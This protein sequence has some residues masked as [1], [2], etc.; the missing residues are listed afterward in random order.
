M[1]K[2]ITFKTNLS[3]QKSEQESLKEI[4]I[5]VNTFH[6]KE[7][8]IFTKLYKFYNGITRVLIKKGR[9]RV[10]WR[11][12]C[13]GDQKREKRER[14]VKFAFDLQKDLA[15]RKLTFIRITYTMPFKTS[16]KK[17]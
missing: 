4:T 3:I 10:V 7:D 1:P 14:P 15:A 9:F 11:S 6:S 12:Q 16:E 17:F 13:N 5:L 8:H 2:V